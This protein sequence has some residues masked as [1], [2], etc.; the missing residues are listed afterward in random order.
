[1]KDVFIHPTALVET[2]EIGPGV[3]VWA[4][5]HIMKGVVVGNDCNIGDHVFIESGARV[6]R[7]VTIKNNVLIWD[8][9]E[10]ADYVFVGPN[11]VFT[12]D[13][14]PRSPR[15][16]DIKWRYAKSENWLVRT[17]VE[18]GASIGA[19]ATILCGIRLGAFCMV[20]AGSVVTRDVPPHR[21]A[22]GNPAR[23]RGYV[24]REGAVLEQQGDFL[25]DPR[26]RRKYKVEGNQLKE[27]PP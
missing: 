17:I 24:D 8:G 23:L 21:L 10:I 19:N 27:C 12:N 7:G 22:V 15:L 26:K 2:T 25:C 3:K 13:L 16:P 18:E 14:F 6:G 1:M 9:V 20:A 11:A 5:A 4:F